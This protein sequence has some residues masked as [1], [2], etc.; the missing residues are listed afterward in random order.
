MVVAWLSCDA[1]CSSGVGARPSLILVAG[2]P[3]RRVKRDWIANTRG[4]PN[5]AGKRTCI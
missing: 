3:D 4:V 5:T 1:E 2:V